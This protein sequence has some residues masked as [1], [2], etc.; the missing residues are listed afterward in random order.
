MSGLVEYRDVRPSGAVLSTWQ[1]PEGR[2]FGNDY[3]QFG[4]GMTPEPPWER[5]RREPGG[6]WVAVAIVREDGSV[7]T[8]HP[9]G[10]VTISRT[11][12]E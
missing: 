2:E 3:S 12:W 7:E 10:T 9:D 8:R 6:E 5:Q 11:W 1:C 4:P